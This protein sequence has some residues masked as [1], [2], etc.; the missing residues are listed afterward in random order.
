MRDI[1]KARR[2]RTRPLKPLSWEIEVE[3][4]DSAEN[5]DQVEEI[6][7][8]DSP[9]V[10]EISSDAPI[11]RVT[12]GTAGASSQELLPNVTISAFAPYDPAPNV[13]LRED[14]QQMQHTTRQNLQSIYRLGGGRMD[15]FV[16]YPV[17]MDHR[18]K[19]LVDHGNLACNHTP[20]FQF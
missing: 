14:F 10:S 3:L 19:M 9:Q 1:G 6:D 15:P 8:A 5:S 7:P 2:T 20:E 13:Q 16:K 18:A 12:F 11:N 17:E 4:P